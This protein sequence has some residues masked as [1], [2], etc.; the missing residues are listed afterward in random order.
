MR[1]ENRQDVVNT[2]LRMD[3]TVVTITPT[4]DGSY[5]VVLDDENGTAARPIAPHVA[6]DPLNAP[7]FAAVVRE[8]KRHAPPRRRA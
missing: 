6:A 1:N 5:E 2:V 4:D 8:L 7:E 3:G